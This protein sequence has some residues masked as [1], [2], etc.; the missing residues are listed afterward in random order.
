[1]GG[2]MTF[3]SGVLLLIALL[4][5]GLLFLLAEATERGW[6]PTRIARRILCR[7]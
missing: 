7:C 4:Y 6:I 2:A 3:D 5:L 1:M